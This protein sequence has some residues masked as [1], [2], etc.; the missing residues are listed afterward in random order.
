MHVYYLSNYH[1]VGDQPPLSSYIF[2]SIKPIQ[3]LA[4]N[5]TIPTSCK[6]DILTG[7]QF[8]WLR[9]TDPSSGQTKLL[10]SSNPVNNCIFHPEHKAEF[11]DILVRVP[12]FIAIK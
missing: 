5:N 3:Y 7:Q 9:A 11:S 6:T 2:S 12:D 1:L 4:V 10:L 8:L